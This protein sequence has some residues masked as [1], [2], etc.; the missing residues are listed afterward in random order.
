MMEHLVLE[1]PAAKPAQGRTL[2]GVV[3]SG[4][5]EV[6]IEAST[7]LRT[8]VTI[9][10]SVDGFGKVWEAVLG[11]LLGAGDLPAVNLE[12][13]DFGATPGVVRMRVAQAFEEL[14]GAAGGETK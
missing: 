9:N 11:R 10:T 7:S 3:A 12:L 8:T 4:D 5:L 13:N 14:A 6:L 2:V 1:F